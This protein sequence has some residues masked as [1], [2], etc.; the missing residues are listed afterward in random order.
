MWICSELNPLC[1]S[2]NEESALRSTTHLSQVTSTTTTSQRQLRTSI[3]E[4][5]SDTRPSTR[6]SEATPSAERSLHRSPLRCEKNQR[7]VDKAYHSHEE[8]LL[9]SQS[10]SG[11][12]LSVGHVR[13]G[14]HVNEYG[15]PSSS[16][17]EK[18]HVATQ[19]MSKSGLLWY[20]KKGRKFSLIVEQRFRNTS[21]KPIMTEEV[22]PN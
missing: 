22:S 14:R 3:Q 17:R 10:L 15:S 6:R 8:S 20:D 2:A 4:P 21:S 13:S 19:K 12:S 7:A 16:V 1:A 5:S 18:T 9:S 11:Q